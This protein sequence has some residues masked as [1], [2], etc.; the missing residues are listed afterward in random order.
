M[1]APMKKA[2]VNFTYIRDIGQAGQNSEVYLAKDEH[3]D[4]EVAIKE[5]SKTKINATD[6]FSEARLL[7]ASRHPNIAQVNY[8]CQDQDNIYVCMPF[9]PNGTISDRIKRS[10]LSPREIIRYSI[11]FLSGLH[12]IHSKSLMHF[13]IKPN[14]I[15][16]SERDEAMLADFGLAKTLDKT[17]FAA[18][19]QI[20]TTHYP[21]E[22]FTLKAYNLT[23]DIYQAGMTIYRMAVGYNKFN[24]ETQKLLSNP[25][26]FIISQ[27]SSGAFPEKTY[28]HH[29]PKPLRAII[30]K[31]LSVD[32]SDRYQSA[33][34]VLN[35]LSSID[36]V[37]LDWRMVDD[38][39]HL[40]WIKPLDQAKMVFKVDKATTKSDFYKENHDGTKRREKQNCK[41]TL[42]NNDIYK[43][44]KGN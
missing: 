34:E 39:S 25:S 32:P 33:L 7:Y 10:N 13:D 28:N 20:Y 43:I 26:D 35:A 42:S 38:I 29:I 44:L 40:I 15:M 21:P 24:D 5:V 37:C 16:L 9:Y 2:D 1:I 30:N 17:G 23:Y 41:A 27:I 36:D 12:H 8:A 31:C 4:A 19:D 18:P 11:N 14:N 6:Y 3:L 22:A